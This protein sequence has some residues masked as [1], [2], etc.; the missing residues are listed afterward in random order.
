MLRLCFQRN[1]EYKEVDP[2]SDTGAELYAVQW[3]NNANN[4]K[5]NKEGKQPNTEKISRE[6]SKSKVWKTDKVQEDK[7]R[8]QNGKIPKQMKGGH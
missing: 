5:S 6:Q 8:I 1:R 2:D 7:T 3:F 4:I